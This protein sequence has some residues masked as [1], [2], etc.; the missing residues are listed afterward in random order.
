[1]NNIMNVTACWP[2]PV[3]SLL[4][5]GTHC[6]EYSVEDIISFILPVCTYNK[7]VMGLRSAEMLSSTPAGQGVPIIHTQD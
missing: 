2:F 7:A 3:R 1:M 5:S 6:T 4:G